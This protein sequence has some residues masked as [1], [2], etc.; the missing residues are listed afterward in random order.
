[1]PG[2]THFED[3][4]LGHRMTQGRNIEH[5]ARLDHCPASGRGRWQALHWLGGRRGSMGNP[6]AQPSSAYG[7]DGPSAAATPASADPNRPGMA[8]WLAFRLFSARRPSSSVTLAV[9]TST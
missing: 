8:A 5:L 1:M 9:R 3:L 2:T 6:A 7:P 4:V